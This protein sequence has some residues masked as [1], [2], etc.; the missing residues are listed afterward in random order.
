MARYLYSE[1]SRLIVARANCE[2]SENNEWLSRH[3]EMIETLVKNHM[4]SGSGFD[5]GTS[6]D[7]DASHG[8]KLVFNTGFHHMNDNGFYSG[9]TEHRVTVT[10]SLAGH[11]H[12]RV[13]GRNRNDIKEYIG[14]TFRH[15]LETD[16]EY[17]LIQSAPTFQALCIELKSEWL[18][19]SRMRW[20]V[21]VDG[22][23]VYTPDPAPKFYA[24]SPIELCKAFAVN[25]WHAHQ[26]DGGK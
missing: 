15:S 14:E 3:E 8:D 22:A 17:D 20:F 12:M 2:R 9:W 10:P 11:Y 25:Y 26:F 16:V 24:G 6:L 13:S 7:L 1:L 4:P 5:S 19:Q 18:D 23:E 21:T